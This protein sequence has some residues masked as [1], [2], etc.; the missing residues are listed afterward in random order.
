[1]AA[2]SL[3]RIGAGKLEG[4]GVLPPSGL[5]PDKPLPSPEPSPKG[6]KRDLFK[7]SEGDG[8]GQYLYPGGVY[9]VGEE[10]MVHPV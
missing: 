4:S 3:R 8:E 10:G 7:K 6:E 2:A 9:P 5:S 1:V